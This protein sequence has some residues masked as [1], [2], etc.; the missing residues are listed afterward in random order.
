MEGI[1]QVFLIGPGRD[2]VKK[3]FSCVETGWDHAKIM[4]WLETVCGFVTYE[5]DTHVVGGWCLGWEPHGH[6]GSL[7]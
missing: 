7:S 6:L 4:Y 1:P 3:W 2:T 5:Y